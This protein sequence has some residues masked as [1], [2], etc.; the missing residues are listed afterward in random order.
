MVS[1][2]DQR[3][4]PLFFVFFFFLGGGPDFLTLPCCCLVPWVH[5]SGLVAILVIASSWLLRGPIHSIG[6]ELAFQKVGL[7]RPTSIWLRPLEKET[8]I[9]SS[10]RD[11]L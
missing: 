5:F 6:R 3:G 2:G 4:Q 10:D 11:T 1:K 8:R 9:S 7:K